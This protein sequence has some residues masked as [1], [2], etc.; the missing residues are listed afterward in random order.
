M[1]L[2]LCLLPLKHAYTLTELP[3]ILQQVS[4]SSSPIKYLYRNRVSNNSNAG[5]PDA[6][7]YTPLTFTQ[8]KEK[9]DA[10]SI[11]Q[12]QFSPLNFSSKLLSDLV[13]HLKPCGTTCCANK[14]HCSL[15]TPC[16]YKFCVIFTISNDCFSKQH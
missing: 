11:F 9:S 13:N 6:M 2:Y 5:S 12:L 7:E 3:T 15:P 14:K 1:Y 4:V 16:I 10:H 8:W